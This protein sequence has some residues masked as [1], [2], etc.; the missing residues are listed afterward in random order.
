MYRKAKSCVKT[1]AGLSPKFFVSN[2]GLRQGENASPVLYSIFFMNDLR[3]F[4]ATNVPSLNLP[5][6][7]ANDLLKFGDFNAFVHLFL[8]LYADDAVILT[9]T[10][11]DRQCALKM[12]K[13][14]CEIRGLQIN[15]DKTKVMIFSWCKIRKIPKCYFGGEEVG[16]LFEYKHLGALFNYNNSF[17]KTIKERCTAANRAMFLLLKRCCSACLPLDIQLLL[18]EKCVYPIL[19]LYG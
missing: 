9:E 16:V 17:I 2:I 1:N 8:L 13:S 11:N 18:Y 4:L 19:L 7:L 10:Q 6:S 12:L 14:Y 3:D 5:F 15:V